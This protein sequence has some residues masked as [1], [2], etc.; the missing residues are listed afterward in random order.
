MNTCAFC[1]YLRFTQESLV[2]LGGFGISGLVSGPESQRF[3]ASK[4]LS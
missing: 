3:M 4:G 1:S 2:E